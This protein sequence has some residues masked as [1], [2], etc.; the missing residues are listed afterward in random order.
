M[1][2]LLLLGA[3][4]LAAVP[5]PDYRAALLSGVE[6][7]AD[8]L[9]AQG[10]LDAAEGLVRDFRAQVADDPR[11]VYEAGLIAN[12]QGKPR[13]AERL[14]RQA[15][16]QDA[17]MAFAWYDLGGLLLAQGDLA[18][19]RDAFIKASDASEDHPKG[20][21][22]PLQLALIAARDQDPIALERWLREGIRRGL[23]FRDI[24]GHPEWT[25]VLRDP[26]LGEVLKR[27]IVVY[28]EES[29]L[30]QWQ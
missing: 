10:E 7:E 19:A 13:D 28:G 2:L 22:A 12:L 15:L 8:A 14:Y 11:L 3:P 21:A 16:D 5:P 9:L 25:E 30:Q 26:T 27:L 23:R 1:T 4:L 29:L 6:A 20:W 24:A 17:G 18:Q